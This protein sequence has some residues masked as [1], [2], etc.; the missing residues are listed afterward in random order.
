MYPTVGKKQAHV[1]ITQNIQIKYLIEE[2]KGENVSAFY[3]VGTGSSQKWTGSATPNKS[4]EVT[5]SSTPQGHLK[6]A[7]GQVN[8]KTHGKRYCE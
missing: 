2:E 8:N 6:N 4:W 5:Y 3:N 7:Q 1:C